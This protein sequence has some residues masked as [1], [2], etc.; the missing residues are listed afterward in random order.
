MYGDMAFDK[1]ESRGHGGTLSGLDQVGLV[2][3]EQG[4]DQLP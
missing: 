2:G 3:Q 1:E 4:A